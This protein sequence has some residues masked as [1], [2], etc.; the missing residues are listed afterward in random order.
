MKMPSDADGASP[1]AAFTSASS[2]DPSA[3]AS[4]ANAL[5]G[6]KSHAADEILASMDPISLTEMDSVA[7]MNRVD[8]KFV[9]GRRQLDAALEE[10]KDQYRVLQVEGVRV[11]PYATLYYDTADLECYRHH[12]N[13]KSNR[14]KFRMRKYLASDCTFLEVKAK[15]NKGRTDKRRVSIPDIE[16]TLSDES[17]KFLRSV[18]GSRLDLQPQ[19]WTY[20]SRTTLVA[21]ERVERV[22]LDWEL[23]FH[24]PEGQHRL[25]DVVIAEIK[26]ESDDRSSPVRVALRGMG[27]RPMRVSKYCLGAALLKPGLKTNRFKS[28]LLRI[29]KIA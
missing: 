7:L 21:R 4:Q 8:T 13:K 18:V 23:D 27:I 11:S 28:K 10:I 16:E 26:Q 15:N 5:A 12:H 29:E 2:T 25:P 14:R 17:V 6:A 9:L 1:P 20:F 24:S 19:M 3:D 22:T